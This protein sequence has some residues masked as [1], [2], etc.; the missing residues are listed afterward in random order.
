MRSSSSITN[1]K[2]AKFSKF[3]VADMVVDLYNFF[4]HP[5]LQIQLLHSTVENFQFICSVTK[6]GGL[7]PLREEAEIHYFKCSSF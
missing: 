1:D 3:T 2:I 6:N 5:S 7:E 4:H